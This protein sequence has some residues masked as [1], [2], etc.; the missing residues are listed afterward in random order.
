MAK[1]KKPQ[2]S[3]LSEHAVRRMMKL[4]EIDSLS[5]QF[6]SNTY[7]DEQDEEDEVEDLEATEA[8]VDD[9]GPPE[10]APV[11]DMGP[12]EEAPVDDIAPEGG[13]GEMPEMTPEAAEAIVDLAASI[14]ASGALEGEGEGEMDMDMGG[15]ED[16]APVGDV[17]LE[18]ED[19]VEELAEADDTEELE[20]QLKTLGIEVIDDSP[21]KLKEAVYKRVVNRLLTEKKKV[22]QSKKVDRMVNRIF[23]RIQKQSK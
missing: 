7:L 8:P 17:G 20:E 15:G 1:K 23:T 4:A 11:D 2:K 10:E 14:E 12:P 13:E 3:L 16:M 19:D 6:V 22:A 9:M 18:D 21:A 5:N